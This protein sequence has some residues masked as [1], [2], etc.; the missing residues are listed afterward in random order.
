MVPV[1]QRIAAAIDKITGPKHRARF[2]V[3]VLE[4]EL[5]RREQLAAL[6]ESAGCWKDENHPELANGPEPFIRDLRSR[7]VDRLQQMQHETSE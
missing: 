7:A 2:V 1:P 4:T 6:E 5:R 3:E